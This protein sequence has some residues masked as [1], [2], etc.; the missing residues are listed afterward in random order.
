M[1]T[2]AQIF[3]SGE[4]SANKGLFRNLVMLARVDGKVDVEEKHLLDR[5][6]GRLSL[7]DEQVEEIK[8]HPENYPMIP[9]V[10]LEERLERLAIFVEVMLID[11]KIAKEEEQ[12]LEKYGAELGFQD[13]ETL[14]NTGFIITQFNEGKKRNDIVDMML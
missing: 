8:S 11:G 13:E 6:A 2:I 14:Q 1:G 7:T 10:S 9:P 3:E 4:Q 12:L 5:I